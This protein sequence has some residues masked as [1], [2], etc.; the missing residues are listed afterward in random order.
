M[1]RQ[2]ML[3]RL[4]KVLIKSQRTEASRYICFNPFKEEFIVKYNSDVVKTSEEVSHYIGRAPNSELDYQRI[5]DRING[6]CIG[7]FGITIFEVEDYFVTEPYGFI[8][9]AQIDREYREQNND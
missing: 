7:K 1:T 4:S 3:D 5:V 9:D 2:E 6:A 8:S